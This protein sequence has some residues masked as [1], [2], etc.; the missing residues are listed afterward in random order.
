MVRLTYGGYV[1]VVIT[2][3]AVTMD[4]ACFSDVRVPENEYLVGGCE[5]QR[6][7]WLSGCF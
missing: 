6:H 3:V 2:L 4:D 5:I 7:V 1:S